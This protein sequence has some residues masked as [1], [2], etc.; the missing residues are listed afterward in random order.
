MNL[1]KKII[2]LS[3][4][5]LLSTCANYKTDK[6]KQTE[7]RKFYSSNGFALIY[8]AGLFEQ[9]GIDNKLNNNKIKHDNIIF[10]AE[11]MLLS[12]LPECKR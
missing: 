5:S 10:F 1:I 3:V 2:L 11:F 4:I 8:D 12:F 7:I 6:P 9:G